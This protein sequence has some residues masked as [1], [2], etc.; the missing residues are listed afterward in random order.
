MDPKCHSQLDALL[1]VEAS[2]FKIHINDKPH[3]QK[4]RFADWP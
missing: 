1:K 4:E 2:R 3:M